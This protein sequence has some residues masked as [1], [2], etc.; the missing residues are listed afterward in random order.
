MPL[1]EELEN[2]WN[3]PLKT[4]IEICCNLKSFGHQNL[5][6][7]ITNVNNLYTGSRAIKKSIY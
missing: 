7:D 1:G 4:V 3:Y 6:L 5:F 2:L